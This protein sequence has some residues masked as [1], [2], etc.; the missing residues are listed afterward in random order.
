MFQRLFRRLRSLPPPPLGRW[1]TKDK[2]KNDLKIDMANV[3]HCGTCSFDEPK[4]TD[5]KVVP[6]P[7]EKS[8]ANS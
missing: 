3:D 2:T 6:P 8:K 7:P 1:C 4:K 5:L